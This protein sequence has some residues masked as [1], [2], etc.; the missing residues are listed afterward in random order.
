MQTNFIV[1]LA[2]KAK[3]INQNNLVYKI[4]KLIVKELKL[5]GDCHNKTSRNHNLVRFFLA[6]S[7]NL[8]NVYMECDHTHLNHN[9]L[10]SQKRKRWSTR[11]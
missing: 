6:Y 11:A 7:H 5:N 3:K 4:H 2:K 1:E 8:V 10:V 9:L